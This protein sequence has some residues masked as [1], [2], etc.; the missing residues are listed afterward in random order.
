[1]SLSIRSTQRSL[2]RVEQAVSSISARRIAVLTKATS[3]GVLGSL[4]MAAESATSESMA[5]FIRFGSG[6]VSVALT[7]ERLQALEL[8]PLSQLHR[9]SNTELYTES[10]DVI[11]GT[12]T[13]ISAQDRTRTVLALADHRTR[14]DDLARPGH[15]FPTQVHRDG[16]LGGK[17]IADAVSDLIRLSRFSSPVGVYSTIVS[18]SG[19]SGSAED[20]E[21]LSAAA[22]LPVL[23]IQDLADYRRWNEAVSEVSSFTTDEGYEVVDFTC[24]DG[25]RQ[26]AIVKG[27]PTRAQVSVSLH[28]AC[29]SGEILNGSDCDCSSRLESAKRLMLASED[30]LLLYLRRPS[31]ISTGDCKAKDILQWQSDYEAGIPQILS[32]LG[33]KRGRL[34]SDDWTT[35]E[36]LEVLAPRP[37]RLAPTDALSTSIDEGN[38]GADTTAPDE[39]YS[40]HETLSSDPNA[41][42]VT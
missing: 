35:A 37:L 9:Q 25:L 12:T 30:F 17:L 11:H 28:W 39:L 6:V 33:V 29:F 34:L 36:N 41:A 27:D 19:D 38:K 23:S 21:A 32:G 5:F 7:E 42:S 20:I 24:P 4:V 8:S 16:I 14:P 1:M 26:S 13:G 40:S 10:V 3:S 22:N 2:D 31:A 18:P 15:V